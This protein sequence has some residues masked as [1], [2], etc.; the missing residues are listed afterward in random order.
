MAD[1]CLK[2]RNRLFTQYFETLP[3]DSPSGGGQKKSSRVIEERDKKRPLPPVT[4]VGTME[5]I[6]H[7]L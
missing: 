2:N 7:Q 3:G 5:A 1:G 6:S 4:Q